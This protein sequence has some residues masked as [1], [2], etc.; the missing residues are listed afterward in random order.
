[1]IDIELASLII[2]LVIGLGQIGVIWYGINRLWPLED[3]PDPAAGN[4]RRE[5]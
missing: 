4:S 5:S 1:M 2:E 3:A